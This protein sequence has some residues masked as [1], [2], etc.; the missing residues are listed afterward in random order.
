M[1]EGLEAGADD[2]IAKSS[3]MAV[4]KV[5]IRALLRRKF[6]LEENRRILDELQEKE[7]R[8]VRA[9]AEKDAAEVRA[10]LAD[11]LAAA[12]QELQSANRRLEEALSVTKAITENAAEGLFMVDERERVSF[13]NPAAERM[14][15]YRA[16]ELLGQPLHDKI[17][18]AGAEDGP[19]P[20]YP[21]RKCLS[22]GERITSYDEILL[23]KDG[24]PVDV[25][26]SIAPIVREG[27]A[28]AAVLVLHDVSERKRAEER[29]RQTQKLESIGLL[30]GGIAHDFNNL[31]TGILGSATLAMEWLPRD[32]DAGRLLQDVVRASERAA[33]LTRQMLAYSGKGRFVVEPVNLSE[34]AADIFELVQPSIPKSVAVHLDL[35]DRLLPVE[36]DAGQMQQVVMNLL[37]NAAEAIGDRPGLVVVRTGMQEVDSEY[38]RRELERAEIELGTYVC[39][40]VRDTGCGMDEATKSKIFDPFFTTKFTGRGL[41]LAAVAGIVRGH[42]GAVKVTSTPGKGS[43]FLVLFP[44]AEAGKTR[45]KAGVFGAKTAAPPAAAAPVSASADEVILV[46]DDEEL[47]LRAAALALARHGYK[48]LRADSGKAAIEI[49]QKEQRRVSLVLLDLSMPGMNGQETLRELRKIRPDVEVIVSSGYSEEE[50]RRLFTGQAISGFIQKPYTAG[51]LARRVTRTLHPTRP[52]AAEEITSRTEHSDVK[53]MLR[54]LKDAMDQA[55]KDGYVAL[56]ATGD[57]MWEFGSEKNLDKLLEYECGLEELLQKHPTLGGI[58]QYHRD[59]LPIHAIQVALY[60]H[61]AVYINQTLSRINPFYIESGDATPSKPKR[62]G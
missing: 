12:N 29:L 58:C 22:T 56:W 14:F 37:L 38:A 33:H 24:T 6:L 54:G 61:Q 30:A 47:V 25:V 21:L 49:F 7:L 52:D 16:A 57:M 59:A 23:R 10:A 3:D 18:R 4:V 28:N 48:V 19:Q 43:T 27:R 2:Y 42:K 9:R 51:V 31:L 50:S 17:C 8:A 34:L 35:A 39:L 36:A 26:C 20:Q 1:T 13:V 55:L 11:R 40:E 44:A 32:S 15:G 41:G 53:L 46:V 45:S 62:D 60:T 5:R